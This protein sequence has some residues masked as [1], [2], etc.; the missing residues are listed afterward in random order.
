MAMTLARVA[1]DTLAPG[2]KVLETAE[3]ETLATMAT[4][5]ALTRLLFSGSGAA[6][7]RDVF[8]IATS[9]SEGLSGRDPSSLE[10]RRRIRPACSTGALNKARDCLV[11]MQP[12]QS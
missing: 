1:G 9:A 12:M 10:P 5:L 3:T 7:V 2:V 8:T 4:S 6:V 11:C